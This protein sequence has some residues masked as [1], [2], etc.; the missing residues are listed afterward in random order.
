M[1][2]ILTCFRKVEMV[3]LVNF[4]KANGAN[5]SGVHTSCCQIYKTGKIARY[6]KDWW[7]LSQ[8][9]DELSCSVR[10]AIHSLKS[11]VSTNFLLEGKLPEPPALYNRLAFPL[12]RCS[13]SLLNMPG[14]PL[15]APF[16][17]APRTLFLS[18]MTDG[19]L[20]KR[21]QISMAWKQRQFAM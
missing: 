21:Q 1:I 18:S 20:F 19:D 14:R 7:F 5:F 15:Y 4:S 10:S 3:K 17:P 11:I 2:A 6:F 13:W 16:S 9:S 12:I 8:K